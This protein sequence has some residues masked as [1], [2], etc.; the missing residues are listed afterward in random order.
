MQCLAG[1]R[2]QFRKE[3]AL[4]LGRFPEEPSLIITSVSPDVSEL[5]REHIG[6]ELQRM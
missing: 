5:G 3:S 6:L 1:M 2:S 4:G